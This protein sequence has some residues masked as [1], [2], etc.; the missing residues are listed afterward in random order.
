[1]GYLPHPCTK[2][3]SNDS[4]GLNDKGRTQFLKVNKQY[5]QCWDFLNGIKITKYKFDICQT[6]FKIRTFHK[7]KTKF[8]KM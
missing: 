2:Q 5:L 6:S 4:T 3:G 1:M 7:D 8:R